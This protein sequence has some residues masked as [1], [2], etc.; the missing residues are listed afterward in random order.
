VYTSYTTISGN[1]LQANRALSGFGGGIWA[2]NST[3]KNNFISENSSD[4]GGGL[5]AVDSQ[6]SDNKI[7]NNTASEG[8]GAAVVDCLVSG[9]ILYANSAG[10]SGGGIFAI[11]SSLA[12]NTISANNAQ[13]SAAGADLDGGEFL[14]NTVV[15]NTVIQSTGPAGLQLSGKPQVHANIFFDN[16]PYDVSVETSTDISGTLNYWGSYSLPQ[17]AGRILDGVDEEARGKFLYEPISLEPS[18]DAPIAPPSNLQITIQADQAHF[19]WNGLPY[20]AG[21]WSYKLYYNNDGLLPYDGSDLSSG[22]S[23]LEAGTQNSITLD[24]PDPNRKYYFALTVYSPE[25]P[26]SWYSNQVKRGLI[27]S[28]HLPLISR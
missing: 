10:K 5:Y 13:Q 19:T 9:N 23:P 6:V 24:N 15:G 1:T 14:G 16:S 4:L 27:Y 28:L 18:Q 20:Y 7:L 8:G 21:L 2:T 3:L 25:G 11:T 22:S 17:I 26:E 12:G